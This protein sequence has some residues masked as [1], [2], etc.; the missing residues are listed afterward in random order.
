MVIQLESPKEFQLVFFKEYL[1]EFNMAIL[2]LSLKLTT[3]NSKRNST[4]YLYSLGASGGTADGNPG[5]LQLVRLE[6]D[7]PKPG[8]FLQQGLNVG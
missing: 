2:K 3:W 1:I 6:D 8:N 5:S 7:G 4:I